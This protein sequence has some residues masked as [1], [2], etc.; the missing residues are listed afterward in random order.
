MST[1][2]PHF[3]N[4]CIGKLPVEVDINWMPQ[5]QQDNLDTSEMPPPVPPKMMVQV[6]GDNDDADA[7]GPNDYHHQMILKSDLDTPAPVLPPKPNK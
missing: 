1:S 7:L 4:H 5:F 6:S 3:D 2:K